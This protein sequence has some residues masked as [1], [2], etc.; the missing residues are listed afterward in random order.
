[1]RINHEYDIYNRKEPSIIYLARPGKNVICAMN[2]IDS[3]TVKLEINTNNTTTLSF[4][5]NK[6]IG[7]NTLSNSYDYIEEMMELYCNGIWFKIV[8]PPSVTFDGLQET[9]DITAESYEVTLS[10]YMLN[11]FKINTGEEGSY[12]VQYKRNYNLNHKDNPEHDPDF[13]SGINPQV[14]FYNPKCPELSLLDLVLKHSGADILGWHVGYVDDTKSE[15]SDESDSAYLANY[16]YY[17]DVDNKSVYSFLTQEVAGICRCVFEFDTVNMTINAYRPEG[18]GVDTELFLGFRN[19]QNNISVLRDTSLITQFYVS[20]ANDYNVDIVNFGSSVITDISH[21]I[22]DLYMPKSLQEKYKRYIEYK[23]DKRKDYI[24]NSKVYAYINEKQTELVNRVPTDSVQTD[25]F[26]SSVKDLKSAYNSNVAIILGLENL[27][28]DADNNFSLNELKKHKSD[29][30]LYSSIM[31]YA[32][33]SIIAALHSKGIDGSEA[34]KELNKLFEN[35][36]DKKL[37]KA[38]FKI[39]GNGNLLSNVNP[40][41][42]NTDWIVCNRLYTNCITDDITIDL[43]QCKGITRGFK[44]YDIT[45]KIYDEDGNEIIGVYEDDYVP[46]VGNE[47]ISSKV[48]K[49]AGN[50]GIIQSKISVNVESYYCL[51]CYI[52]ASGIPNAGGFQLSYAKSSNKYTPASNKSY[53]IKKANDWKKCWLLFK[54]DKNTTLIDVAFVAYTA[55]GIDYRNTLPFYICGMQ[56]EELSED[57]Y[58]NYKSNESNILN[59]GFGY[60][61]ENNDDIKAYETNWDL[62]GIDELKVKIKTYENCMLELKKKGFNNTYNSDL[63]CDLDYYSQM[64]QCYKDYTNLVKQ[65]NDALKKRQ[66]EY[67]KLQTGTVTNIDI[68]DIKLND[69]GKPIKDKND[70]TIPILYT[71]DGGI[72]K[73][74]NMRLFIAKDVDIKNWGKNWK[75][76][77][78]IDMDTNYKYLQGIL[79]SDELLN[80]AFTNEEFI[81]L[82]HLYRQA[83]YSNE[84]I[85]ITDLDTSVTAVKQV[86]KLFDDAVKE[87]YVESHPQYIYSDSIENIYALPELKDYHDRFNV[88]DYVHIELND[89]TFITLR[90]IKISYNPCDLDESMEITFSNMIQYASK[91]DDYNSLLEGM[92]NASSHDAGSIQGK[93]NNGSNFTVSAEVIQQLL[94]NPM[95]TS[96]ISSS[97]TNANSIIIDLQ[98]QVK[99]LQAELEKLKDKIK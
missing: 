21:F 4:S 87:L 47:N 95:F 37:N 85:E 16:L 77:Y 72:N 25:W 79:S 10:Q 5:V 98:N 33:P 50:F 2:G 65:A 40:V 70:K 52:K 22:N 17:Y 84:N 75:S 7:E 35:D 24:F 82:T 60:F 44:F 78:N 51:S 27:Y 80:E 76:D 58:N 11:T 3:S 34:I 61:I 91:R 31:D 96:K 13:D 83:N 53:V 43:S 57:E 88:N 41:V 30:D 19:I 56:L 18:L 64:N 73:A 1:M 74:N 42:I 66:A 6:Y 59:A 46:D 12:E 55:A 9:K 36:P 92:V 69:N 49:F 20:G 45:E 39:T 38:Q 94:S 93:S 86:K 89:N 81:I 90:L 29:W 99:Q 54:T 62:Y 23:E 97:D 63:G 28:V 67:D 68:G 26:S 15:S 14:I 48:D 8:D 32:L 71:F